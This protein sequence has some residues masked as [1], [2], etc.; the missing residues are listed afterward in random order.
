MF[1]NNNDCQRFSVYS[2]WI[3]E[4]KALVVRITQFLWYT[5][6]TP[7]SWFISD[8][9]CCSTHDSSTA[10][11]NHISRSGSTQSTHCDVVC[12]HIHCSVLVYWYIFLNWNHDSE[13]FTV[14]L[15]YHLYI[16][17]EH[18]LFMNVI[19]ITLVVRLKVILDYVKVAHLVLRLWLY[20][21]ICFYLFTL[22]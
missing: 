13:L 16:I 12:L 15:V 1:K 4:R 20:L 18:L 10:D 5:L 17:T 19:L 8:S 11:L 9:W 6:P 22:I 7:V 14:Y 2:E 3:Y 21:I